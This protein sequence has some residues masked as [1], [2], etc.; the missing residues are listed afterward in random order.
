VAAGAVSLVAQ[1]FGLGNMY[2][3]LIQ[4][5]AKEGF[6]DFNRNGVS[7]SAGLVR[8]ENEICHNSNQRGNGSWCYVATSFVQNYV[9]Y[10]F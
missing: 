2:T 9:A 5:I 10:I 4:L 6:F 8:I 3:A 7:F 1:G